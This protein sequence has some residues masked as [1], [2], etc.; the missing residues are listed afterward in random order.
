MLVTLFGMITFVKPVQPENVMFPML[1][2]LLGI[3]ILVN[4]SHLINAVFP[5]TVTVLPKS[6][7]I[8]FV[9]SGIY[10]VGLKFGDRPEP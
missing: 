1:V 10:V 9:T 8:I 3:I 4:L 5:K 6:T 7:S 2:T